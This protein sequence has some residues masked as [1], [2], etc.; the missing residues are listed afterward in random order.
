MHSGSLV[1]VCATLTVDRAGEFAGTFAR[2]A[3]DMARVF[4]WARP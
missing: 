3:A 4:V 2:L 1:L